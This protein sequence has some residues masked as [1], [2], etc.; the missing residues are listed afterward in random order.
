MDLL[1]SRPRHAPPD[2]R[3]TNVASKAADGGQGQG[4]WPPLLFDAKVSITSSIKLNKELAKCSSARDVLV[5]LE[6]A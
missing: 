4:R 5:A 6:R 3:A 2:T 1:A